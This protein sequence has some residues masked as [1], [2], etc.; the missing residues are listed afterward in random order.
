MSRR[1]VLLLLVLA[2]PATG[3]LSNMGDLKEALGIVEAP[4]PP[5]PPTPDP[6][7][8]L[9]RAEANVSVAALGALV[10]FTGE[11]SRDADGTIASFA[12]DFGD[13]TRA[14]GRTVEHAFA[15]AGEFPVTLTVVD[16]DGLDGLD[17]VIVTIQAPNRAPTIA[18]EARDAAGRPT[19]SGDVREPLALRAVA[20]DADGDALAIEWDLGDGR[21]AHGTDTVAAFDRPG[22]HTV[23]AVARDPDGATA[24]AEIRIAQHANYSWPSN[25]FPATAPA[26]ASMSFPAPVPEGAEVTIVLEFD[27]ALG[28][29]DLA[30]SVRDAAGVEVAR[31]ARAPSP[32]DAGDAQRVIV[33]DRARVRAATPGDWTILVEKTRG[34]SPTFDLRAAIVA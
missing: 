23:R 6:V 17:R 16:E 32:G 1:T 11:R 25:A 18:I 26:D 15:A 13:G 28:T 4:P 5:L 33:L 14:A 12:W 7:P 31:D 29:A 10:R 30:L 34:V 24:E 3:C 8:P 2:S 21:S 22:R 9:A 27:P 20:S 19:S